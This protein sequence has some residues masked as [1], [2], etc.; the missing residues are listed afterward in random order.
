MRKF[1]SRLEQKCIHLRFK[2]GGGG[3]GEIKGESSSQG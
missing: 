1:K 3:G 2:E